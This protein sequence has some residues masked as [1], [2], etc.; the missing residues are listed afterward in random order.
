M[1]KKIISTLILGVIIT[2]SSAQSKVG[3]IPFSTGPYTLPMNNIE[4]IGS[5]NVG[6]FPNIELISI[7]QFISEYKN[8]FSFLMV[9][10]TSRYTN[11]ITSHFGT[12]SDHPVIKMFNR[13]SL[14]PKMLNFNAPSFIML[15]L[16]NNLN[17]RQD[18]IPDNFVL[19]RIGGLDSLKQFSI[20]LKDFAEKSSFNNFFNLHSDYYKQII[21]NARV[22]LGTTD[23]TREIEDFYGT[24]QKGYNICLV[25][26]YNYVG[27]GNSVT[28]LKGGSEVF[29]VIGAEKI[30]NGIP[31]FGNE[32]YMKPF[33]RHE[34][35]HPF[36]NPIT[37]KNWDFIKDFSSNYDSIPEIAKK[38]VCGD[39]QECINEF[40][41]RAVTVYLALRENNEYGLQM[42]KIES[43]RGVSKL[44]DLLEKIK[45]YEQNRNLYPTFESYY[46]KL[47]EVYMH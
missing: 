46:R 10:D 43:S 14:K 26:T 12:F 40:T 38:N 1:M 13:L 36:V 42:H 32:S 7:I 11:D 28:L 5:L 15:Y 9:Q 35:S 41:I 18:I 25:S 23:F 44:D 34:L 24:K 21:K 20:L 30:I 45:Y 4:K 39:W 27:F 16:D 33:I 37:E 47:L 29:T 17:I 2:F 31:F 6:V 19:S 8:V 3:E 22:G